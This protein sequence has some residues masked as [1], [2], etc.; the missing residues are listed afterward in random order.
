MKENELRFTDAPMGYPLCFN[1]QCARRDES[2][3]ENVGFSRREF[4]ILMERNHDS[5]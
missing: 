4:L 2:L 5:H 1:H 3:C